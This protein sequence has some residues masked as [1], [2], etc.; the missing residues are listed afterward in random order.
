MEKALRKVAQANMRS[1]AAWPQAL[2]K[3]LVLYQQMEEVLKGSL[4][5]E[6]ALVKMETEAFVEALKDYMLVFK[7][8]T[9]LGDGWWISS[10]GTLLPIQ[11]KSFEEGM[12]RYFEG[13][14]P[15]YLVANGMVEPMQRSSARVSEYYQKK[16]D[17][18]QM[19]NIRSPKTGQLCT[20]SKGHAGIHQVGGPHHVVEQFIVKCPDQLC[21]YHSNSKVDPKGVVKEEWMECTRCGHRI[22]MSEGAP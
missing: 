20:L 12:E 19:C 11:L 18:G 22:P 1:T 4:P 6:H 13:F 8:E 17:S 9:T 15:P 3:K 14:N 2:L 16:R 10:P 21:V 7:R 5:K